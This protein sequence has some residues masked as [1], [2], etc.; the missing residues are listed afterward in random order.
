MSQ[1]ANRSGGRLSV[2]PSHSEQMKCIVSSFLSEIDPAGQAQNENGSRQAGKDNDGNGGECYV[3]PAA[4]LKTQ[5]RFHDRPPQKL[6]PPPKSGA[7]LIFRA[8][9]SVKAGPF[10]S[11]RSRQTPPPASAVES[12]VSKPAQ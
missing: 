1:P 12:A 4:D 10:E 5:Q 6:R 2:S 7:T 3:V 9:T 11:D 8:A